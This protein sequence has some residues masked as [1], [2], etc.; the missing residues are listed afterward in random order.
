MAD[1]R[2]QL[3]DPQRQRSDGGGPVYR[4]SQVFQGKTQKETQGFF[5]ECMAFL[6]QRQDP[7][8]YLSTVVHMDEKPPHIHLSFVPLT[9]DE[10][11]SAKEIVGNR[12]KLT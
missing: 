1:C 6:V 10:R 11:L 4:Q 2:D 5:K 9:A 3:R 8:T 7:A 12:K